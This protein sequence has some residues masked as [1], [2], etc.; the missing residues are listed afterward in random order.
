MVTNNYKPDQ[1]DTTRDVWKAIGMIVDVQEGLLSAVVDLEAIEVR[2][3]VSNAAGTVV[4]GKSARAGRPAP[5]PVTD[6]EADEKKDESG[7]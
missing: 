3:S 2:P 1:P 4:L 5:I 6:P 7:S